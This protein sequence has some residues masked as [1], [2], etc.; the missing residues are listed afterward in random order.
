MQSISRCVILSLDVDSRNGIESMI[1]VIYAGISRT[2]EE[3]VVLG[4]KQNHNP[5]VGG[6]SPSSATNLF[7]GLDKSC[8]THFPFGVTHGVT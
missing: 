7:N 3:L 1:P 5:R 2:F 8:L 4:Q 6:S